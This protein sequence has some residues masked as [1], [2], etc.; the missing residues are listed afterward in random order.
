M[1]FQQ[2]PFVDRDNLPNFLNEKNLVNQ[3]V[4]IGT[5]RGEFAK[6]ILE[7]WNGVSL[8]CVDHWSIP[9]G[10]EY[11]SKCLGEGTRDDHL[12]EALRNVA[13]YGKKCT[14][15]RGFSQEV[16]SRI[17]DNSLD[18]VY[19]DGDHSEEGVLQDLCDWWPKIKSGGVLA[20]HDIICPGEINLGWGKPI[21]QA[22]QKWEILVLKK[23][24]TIYLVVETLCL[25]WSFYIIKDETE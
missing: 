1:L 22:L 9:E 6:Q 2:A 5:H 3:G 17:A 10:Y 7:K 23:E 20:G 11:Q 16:C 14:L 18:F 19:L 25:P 15:I 8:M 21:Q 12:K 4:E 13:K 24:V